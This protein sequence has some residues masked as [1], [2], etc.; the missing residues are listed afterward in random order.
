[1][2][3]PFDMT[4]VARSPR[5][6]SPPSTPW[7]TLRVALCQPKSTGKILVDRSA[8]PASLR[9]EGGNRRAAPSTVEAHGQDQGQ[10]IFVPWEDLFYGLVQEP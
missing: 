6:G 10:G 2:E 5:A 1:M 3:R 8:L 7:G 4:D 9:W